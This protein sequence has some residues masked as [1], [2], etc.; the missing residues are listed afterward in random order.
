MPAV[1]RDH[2]T[3]NHT[4][5]QSGKTIMVFPP[6]FQSPPGYGLGSSIW[7]EESTNQ[8]RGGMMSRY[9]QV[10]IH[11]APEK[12]APVGSLF[13]DNFGTLDETL[14]VYEEGAALTGD[15][16]LRFMKADCTYLSECPEGLAPVIGHQA[17]GCILDNQQVMPPGNIKDSIHLASYPGI[18]H[19]NNGPGLLGDR[20]LDLT[21]IQV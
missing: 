12:L 3:P 4:E 7:A 9:P 10:F 14:I 6:D 2:W 20:G 17:L 15:Q 5:L 18:M 13:P 8:L 11:L 21:F 19:R 1:G 16:V